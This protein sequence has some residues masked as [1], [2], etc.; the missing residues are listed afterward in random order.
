MG[1]GGS[2]TETRSD[3]T[4]NVTTNTTTTIRDV[5][6]TGQ[7]AIDALNALEG[8]VIARD[9]IVAGVLNN[10]IQGQGSGFSQ[11]VGGAS[12]LVKTAGSVAL[13]TIK[14]GFD[15][16]QKSATVAENT[17]SDALKFSAATA[18]PDAASSQKFVWISIAALALVGVIALR[19]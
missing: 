4:T 15:T 8:G 13:E 12:D 19:K 16:A 1:G 6:L 9:Q 14:Q 18:Q 7:N 10:V 17:L 11:L 2:S 5:G 3:Q